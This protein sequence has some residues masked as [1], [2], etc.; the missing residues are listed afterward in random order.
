V[1]AGKGIRLTAYILNNNAVAPTYKVTLGATSLAL[2][3]SA[4]ANNIQMFRIEM[5][6]NSGVQNAQVWTTYV[7]DSSTIL[8][9]GIVTSTENFANAV[10]LKIT[11]NEANPNAVTPKKW[12]VELI[13]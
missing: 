8:N 6:N 2:T 4:F 12:I 10:T 9:T 5:F 13:Q 11:A 7:V 3:P 1:Q